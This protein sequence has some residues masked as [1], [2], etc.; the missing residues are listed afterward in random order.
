MIRRLLTIIFLAVIIIFIGLRVSKHQQTGKQQADKKP[1]SQSEKILKSALEI[2]VTSPQEALAK[3]EKIV[4]EYPESKEAAFALMEK[5]DIYKGQNKLLQAKAEL[6][7]IIDAYSN[8]EIIEQAKSKLWDLNI[9]IIF[10]QTEVPDSF[11]YDVN[12]GDT[13]FRIAKK[14]DTTV[15]LLMKSNNLASTLIK[16]DMKLKISKAIYKIVV[17]KS[18]N[19]LELK[20][21]VETV[22]IYNVSTGANNST[23]TGKFKI[24]NRIV[25]PVWYKTGAVVPPG[26]PENILGTRWLGLSEPGYG[27]HGTTEPQNIGQ[28]VTQGCVRMRNEEVEE[29]F[30]IVPTGAEVIIND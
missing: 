27:I 20:N 21:N 25:N 4:V 10:S 17:S 1:S 11:I 8:S 22:K 13:L 30:T 2:K 23:P 7:K 28:S 12:P 24:V 5:A 16:P 6:K 9:S 26:S 14:F 15:E 3:L 19:I 29:L 18:K